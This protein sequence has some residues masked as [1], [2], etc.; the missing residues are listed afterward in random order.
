MKSWWNRPSKIP[1]KEIIHS[2]L[3]ASDEREKSLAKSEN[4]RERNIGS[5]RPLSQEQ[6]DRFIPSMKLD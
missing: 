6:L 2:L 5:P 3:V 1:S 4:E